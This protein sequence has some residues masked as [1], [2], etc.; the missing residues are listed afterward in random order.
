ML[1]FNCTKAA[2]DF[3]TT[4]KKGEKSSP[5]E[6]APHKTIPESI[7]ESIANTNTT[8]DNEHLWHWVVHA[9]KIKR[10][11][12][13]VVMDYQSRFSITLTGLKKGDELGF[14]NLLEHHLIVHVHE[15]MGL[16]AEHPQ[17]IED[18][19]ESYQQQ[20]NNCAF[21]PRGDRS[22]QAHI[23]DVLWHFEY[24][25]N[26]TGEV[27]HGIDLIGFDTYAN[28]I[29]RK[30]KGEK[31]YFYPQ[32]EFLHLWLTH[33]GNC[34][35]ADADRQIEQL[36][37]KER[38]EAQSRFDDITELSIPPESQNSSDTAFDKD[39]FDQESKVVSLDAYRK[40]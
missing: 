17:T 31:D 5:I 24:S 23:N 22:V 11:N 36:Q 8:G 35:T 37:A 27:P 28:R 3:F 20:Q 39:A 13:L 32:H 16:V 6:P 26:E 33:Y 1:I 2:A 38:T 29:L 12:V 25:V 9:K 14:L 10:K 15:T 21:Y 30:R 7:A 4:T 40:K 34:N 18:S 19:L